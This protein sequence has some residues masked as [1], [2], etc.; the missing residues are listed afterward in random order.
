L[1]VEGGRGE[2]VFAAAA[3]PPHARGGTPLVCPGAVDLSLRPGSA[4]VDAGA[5]IA[6]VNDGFAGQAPDTGSLGLGHPSPVHGPRDGAFR[7][8]L[9]ALRRGAAKRWR[10]KRACA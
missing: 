9:E 3:E 10:D 7:E 5:L 4:P 2:G 1:R 8:R 6:G